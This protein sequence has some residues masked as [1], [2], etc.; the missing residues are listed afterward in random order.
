MS[1]FLKEK[2][3]T[4]NHT[5]DLHIYNVDEYHFSTVQKEMQ[6]YNFCQIHTCFG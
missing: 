6:E 1:G 2:V 5:D 3:L 4:E